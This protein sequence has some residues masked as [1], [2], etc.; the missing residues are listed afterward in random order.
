M[1]REEETISSE[2]RAES[3]T[4]SRNMIVYIGCFWLFVV[5]N[6]FFIWNP[7]ENV[8]R[9]LAAI[10]VF[11]STIIF[12]ELKKIKI[13]KHKWQFF[14][15]IFIYYLYLT[16]IKDVNFA[17][18]IARASAFI[19]M[20][21]MIF[22]PDSY[23]CDIYKLF[24]KIIIF[25]AI[26]SIIIAIL[27]VSGLLSHIPY[28]VLDAQSALHER[29]NI[30][31]RV[32]FCIVTIY[33]GNFSLIPRACGMLQE[34]GHFSII[35]GFVYLT[36]RLLNNKGNIWIVIC[37]VLTFSF[38]FI[39]IACLGEIYNMIYNPKF[40]KTIKWVLG[41]MTIAIISFFLLPN[42]LR[43]TII[44]LVYGRNMEFIVDSLMS[45][46][47]LEAALDERI[48]QTG[49]AYYD[50]FMRSQNIW[51]GTEINDDAI[52]LSDYR[53]MIF[54]LGIVGLAIS[55][56]SAL[57]SSKGSLWKIRIPIICTLGLI[58]LHR[59]WM[60]FAPYWYFLSYMAST[61]YNCREEL[62]SVYL[63]K[64]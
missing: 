39:I 7:F 43:E 63:N 22:W 15:V 61:L 58:F 52:V 20:L 2:R 41:F 12:S 55:I 17:A 29:L 36:D 28:Y 10:A 48:N 64:G 45:S 19:P 46:G 59:S 8:I 25:F 23:L 56:Y 47:S 27:S 44:Y 62:D 21:L 16:I 49:A 33:D 51:F 38:N 57:M 34:P 3:L 32:Y 1:H 53:G 11:I 9:A 30:V 26:G 40:I 60:M 5:L 42:D 6:S 35:L 4:M 18:K 24:R 37:G 31:Y 54:N 50:T 14:V 13:Y